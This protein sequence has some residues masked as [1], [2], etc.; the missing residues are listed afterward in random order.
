LGPNSAS[1][2]LTSQSAAH[3]VGASRRR[4]N[5][6]PAADWQGAEEADQPS[7]KAP[8]R[9]HPVAA[10]VR[11]WLLDLK[12]SSRSP[13]TIR[14]YE[15][16]M[17]GYAKAGGAKSLE[18][19]TPYELK[20][21]IAELQE[22]GL[23]PETIRGSFST[24]RA[25]ASWARSQGYEVD[26]GLS[27]V[28]PPKVPQKEMPTFTEPQVDAIMDTLPKGW[29]RIAIQVLLGTGMRVGELC[30]LQL[31]DFED[32]EEVA[33]LK[34]QQGKGG[35]F[36][37]VPVSQKL[38]RELVRYL[39]QSRPDT[40]SNN[41]I[42]LRDGRP[43]VQTST[44]NIFGRM[45]KKLGIQVHAHKFRHTFATQYLRNGGEIE[46]LRRILGHSTYFMVMR[47]VHLDKGD[48]GRDFDLRS[49][50]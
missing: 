22:R 39:N 12:V 7:L 34:I 41:L 20:R 18:E 31:N 46:R 24:L 33:F 5:Q 26:P 50:F 29:Q 28:K 11:E 21:Y 42:V 49:P 3:A 1:L 23:S 6:Q 30:A 37:R 35:K 47:Y 32:D 38:R 2:P 45:S 48:L 44:N 16:K 13:R 25:F 43:I 14:W 10:L 4:L 27:S 19:L 9:S 36:R 8:Q 15:Q 17:H 40:T